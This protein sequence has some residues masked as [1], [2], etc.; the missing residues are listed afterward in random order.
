LFD[1]AAIETELTGQRRTGGLF[2]GKP[3]RGPPGI[4]PIALPHGHSF[5]PNWNFAR[6]RD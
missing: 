6:S 4:S 1:A 5:G 3:D 2:T